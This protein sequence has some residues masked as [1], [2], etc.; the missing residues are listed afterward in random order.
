[1][2]AAGVYFIYNG[3][4]WLFAGGRDDSGHGYATDSFKTNLIFCA[5]SWA[6]AAVCF[7]LGA[8]IFEGN[9]PITTLAAAVVFVVIGVLRFRSNHEEGYKWYVPTPATVL[10]VVYPIVYIVAGVLMGG[11]L[12]LSDGEALFQI[13]ATILLIAG[14]AMWIVRSVFVVKEN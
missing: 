1:M 5:I 6:I 13:F 8:S 9:A 10:G 12:L 11:A 7:A 3:I 2:Y 4:R 14:F